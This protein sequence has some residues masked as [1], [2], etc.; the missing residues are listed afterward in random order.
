MARR[1]RTAKVIYSL[2]MSNG[3]TRYAVVMKTGKD[4]DGVALID[5]DPR[6]LKFGTP[7]PEIAA[8]DKA[9][10]PNIV[11]AGATKFASI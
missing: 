3:T 9:L 10:Y 1:K 4:V 8:Q 5:V 6:M 7:T 2:P 11:V